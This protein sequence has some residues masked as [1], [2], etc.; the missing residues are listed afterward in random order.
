MRNINVNHAVTTP[1][2]VG[3]P[4]VLGKG[5]AQ[6]D[7]ESYKPAMAKGSLFYLPGRRG[8]LLTATA[9]DSQP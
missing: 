4:T 9:R 7:I 3:T 2:P 5:V 6:Q 8:M 1:P